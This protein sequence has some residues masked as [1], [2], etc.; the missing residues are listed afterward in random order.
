MATFIDWSQLE[1]KVSLYE[2][3]HD[4]DN[5]S[6]A[7]AFVLLERLLDLSPEEVRDAI[8]DGGNDRGVDAVFIDD[9]GEK[10]SVHIFQFKYTSKFDKANNNFPG[11]EIDKLL[12]FVADLLSK[13]VSMKDTC[14]PILWEKVQEIWALLEKGIVPAFIVHLCGNMDGLVT[15]EFDR[16]CN[17]LAPYRHF[18]VQQHTLETI[19]AMIIDKNR[20][21]IDGHLR[22][23]DK[24][25]F[26]R[27]DGNIRGL[28][29]TVQATELINLIRD[30][31]DE[32]KVRL[33]VF[34]DNVR[35]YL[36]R[37]N[38]INEKI[39]KSA[40]A[41]NAEFWYLNNGITITC[42]SLQYPPGTRAPVLVL[43]NVQIVN[44]GQTS[45]ALFEAY[46]ADK[47][48]LEDVLVLVK[49][50][51][52]KEREISQ[53]IAESTN[54]QT[55]I[56]SRDLRAN[57][58]VQ[59]KLEEEFRDLGYL[60]ERK[61]AQH[62]DS[63]KTK[64]IDALTAGQA[65][66]AYYLEYPEVAKKD[67]GRVFGDLYEV[68]F[69]TEISAQSLLT[70]LQVSEPIVVRKRALQS[71]MRR[72]QEF[73]KSHLFLL[74]GNYHVLYVIRLL[75]EHRNLAKSDSNVAKQQLDDAIEIV[76][77]TVE[78]ERAKDPD[79]FRVNVFF[80]DADTKKKLRDVLIEYVAG[81][82]P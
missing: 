68:V 55:P 44:G 12:S 17:S 39:F 42:D 82:K 75:C 46:Q 35:V 14:N 18:E 43:E 80:K 53:K 54:S 48:K 32:S 10:D 25:Y 62:A 22:L 59:K 74:E 20:K 16:L 38:P 29:A 37:K 77:L 23:V 57:D 61:T 70:P 56:R 2:R 58:D 27:V 36:T 15:A 3:I 28:I 30:P 19:V 31:A 51:E 24:Q 7:L 50:Y 52:T 13:D 60:Y 47:E 69:S 79:S 6:V 5:K 72:G 9:R 40:L 81:K 76:K 73:D 4:C 66:L 45:N 21:Q 26:E 11:A 78:R 67:R 64:R 49:V 65:Y 8:T 63:D 1:T 41:Q 33:D 34:N 71:A